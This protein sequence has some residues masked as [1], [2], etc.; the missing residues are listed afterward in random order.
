MSGVPEVARST[1]SHSASRFPSTTGSGNP[2]ELLGRP[3]LGATRHQ[4][5][6]STLLGCEIPEHFPPANKIHFFFTIYI[7]VFLSD[8]ITPYTNKNKQIQKGTYAFNS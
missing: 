3:Y 7:Y 5:V 4:A 2:Q 1:V 6:R 8:P